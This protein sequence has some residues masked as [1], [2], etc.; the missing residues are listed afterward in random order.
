MY[1]HP[2]EWCNSET[3]LSKIHSYL[4][5]KNLEYWSYIRCLLHIQ[6]RKNR[7]FH[8]ISFLILFDNFRCPRIW[9]PDCRCNFL[10]CDTL[11]ILHLRAWTAQ[12]K[13]LTKCELLDLTPYIENMKA[14]ETSLMLASN[15]INTIGKQAREIVLVA[16]RG[17]EHWSLIKK[18]IRDK[19]VCMIS[20]YEALGALPES[21]IKGD[22]SHRN[23]SSD[24]KPCQIS[25]V[26]MQSFAGAF[27]RDWSRER[28][29]F[30]Y[31]MTKVPAFY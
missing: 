31:K 1:H 14:K 11:Q 6:G 16:C 4:S 10:W 7:N 17:K 28:D 21:I 22:S 23:C 24:R 2:G 5:H 26:W 3:Q 27:S 30:H 8:C 25:V 19:D 9:N 29:G 18:K 12:V 20:V 13:S 15:T